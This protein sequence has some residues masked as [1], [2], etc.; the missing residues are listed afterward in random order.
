MTVS[1]TSLTRLLGIPLADM[2]AL[3]R[4]FDPRGDKTIALS[5]KLPV[6]M[7]RK[8]L[9]QIVTPLLFIVVF[10]VTAVL[11]HIPIAVFYVV[12]G[13]VLGVINGMAV[14]LM[15]FGDSTR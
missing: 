9:M 8:F 5:E 11:L 15:Y 7:G 6:L 1:V 10:G 13:V 3:Y 2:Q 12:C 4:L 14:T